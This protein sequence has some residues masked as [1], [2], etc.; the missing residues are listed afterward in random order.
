MLLLVS[1]FGEV[2]KGVQAARIVRHV[3]EEEQVQ[4]GSTGFEYGSEPSFFIY[5]LTVVSRPFG[6]VIYKSFCN[7]RLTTV[8]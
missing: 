5:H 4:A 2:W 7:G 6:W 1:V 8:K 3:K